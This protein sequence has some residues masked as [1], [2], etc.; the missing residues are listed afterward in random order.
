MGFYSKTNI[1][2]QNEMTKSSYMLLIYCYLLLQNYQKGL[3]Y[4]KVLKSDFKL[5]SKM[6]FELKMYM[7]EIYL[8]LG[9]ET[10]AFKCL[11]IDQAFEEG[12][13]GASSDSKENFTS[14]ENT[15]SGFIEHNLPKRAVMFLNIATCNYLLDIPDTAS[16]AIANA[17]DSLNLNKTETPASRKPVIE[18]IPEYLLHSLV[19][20]NLFSG[21]SETA[22]KLLRKRRFDKV[23]ESLLDFSQSLAPLK[24]F[25]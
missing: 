7:T 25:K 11:K 21:D 16:D 19:Y 24:V 14:I 9:K 6:N 2:R 15:V 3:D 8:N 13:D 4:C 10:L 23:N 20:L 12:K 22:L 5:N 18:E 17:L 1:E